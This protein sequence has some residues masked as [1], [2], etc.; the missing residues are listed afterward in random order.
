M[1]MKFFSLMMLAIP[2]L[3]SATISPELEKVFSWPHVSKLDFIL[4]TKISVNRTDEN[5]NISKDRLN[6]SSHKGSYFVGYDHEGNQDY[7]ALPVSYALDNGEFLSVM[8]VGGGEIKNVGYLRT[9]DYYGYCSYYNSQVNPWPFVIKELKNVDL[10]KL[11]LSDNQLKIIE[12]RL[13]EVSKLSTYWHSHVL[14]FGNNVKGFENR[15]D[16]KKGTSLRIKLAWNLEVIINVKLLARD[17]LMFCG[18]H[19]VK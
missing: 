4:K 13:A 10:K 16:M 1:K 11:D 19:K 12:K 17:P 6:I 5:L 8:G 7:G 15:E 9:P 18:W 14:S 2:L 3:A